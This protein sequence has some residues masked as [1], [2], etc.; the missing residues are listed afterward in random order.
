MTDSKLHPST[1]PKPK[2]AVRETIETLA[3]SVLLALGIRTFV[4]EARYIPL[5]AWVS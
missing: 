3:L 5:I 4:A 2:G 1:A